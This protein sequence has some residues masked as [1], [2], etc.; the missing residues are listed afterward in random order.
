MA[1]QRILIRGPDEGEVDTQEAINMMPDFTHIK[2]WASNGNLTGPTDVIREINDGCSFIYFAGHGSPFIWATHVPGV[3]GMVTG[4]SNF[5]MSKLRNRG[6]LPICFMK[7]C[8]VSLFNVGLF[9]TTW[10]P[11]PVFESLCWRLTRKMGGGSIATIGNTALSYGPKD[12]LHR[13]LIH[14]VTSTVTALLT[15]MTWL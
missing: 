5:H 15:T 4:L 2:L 6:K 13:P 14:M 10:N 1:D 9:H 8:H 7:A 11:S 3:E 12:V